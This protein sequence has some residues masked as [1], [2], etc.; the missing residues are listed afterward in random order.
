MSSASHGQ[1]PIWTW[2]PSIAISNII[3]VE[4]FL[5]E[6]NGDL[7]VSSLTQK[8]LHRI[9]YREGRAIFDEPIYIGSS[10]RDLDQ[11]ADGTIVLWTD[12][13]SI[14]ELKPI[15]MAMPSIE[16]MVSTLRGTKKQ[17]A[18]GT[19]ESCQECHSVSPVGVAENAPSLWGVF[20][21][22]IAGTAFNGY[23]DGL[24][25]KSGIWNEESLDAYLKDVDEFSK[26]S[27]MIFPA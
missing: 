24:K 7:L 16:E 9:R 5:P 13:A 8:T 15:E 25:N 22:E 2:V 12:K 10:I 1:F 23:S 6:W 4:G 21:R 27:N 3:Q 26:D 18:L 14:V 19:I 17:E 20:G 11:L